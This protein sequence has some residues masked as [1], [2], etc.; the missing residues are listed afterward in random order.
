MGNPSKERTQEPR[1]SS[2]GCNA[3]TP[4]MQNTAKATANPKTKTG[5]NNR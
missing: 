2:P 3:K 4:K 5:Y 1:K